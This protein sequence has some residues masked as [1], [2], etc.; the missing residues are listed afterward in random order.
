MHVTLPLSPLSPAMIKDC[1]LDWVILGHS[2]RRHVFGESDE[3]IGQKVSAL[4]DFFFS[5]LLSSH[6]VCSL[7]MHVR[8]IVL[9]QN[10]ELLW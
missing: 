7:H 6:S 2:E 5:F 10:K 4:S 9:E 8:Y 1:G 3:L